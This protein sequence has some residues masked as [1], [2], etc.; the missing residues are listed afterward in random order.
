MNNTNHK[1]DDDLKA[2]MGNDSATFARRVANANVTN[3]GMRIESRA[4][5]E[6][7]EREWEREAGRPGWM[8]QYAK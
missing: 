4:T 6:H 3:A 5:R 8:K 2:I 7:H 1:T